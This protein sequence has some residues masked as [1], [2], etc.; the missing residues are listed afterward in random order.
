[1]R[2]LDIGRVCKR[3][4]VHGGQ[5]RTPSSPPT[6]FHNYRSPTNASTMKAQPLPMPDL[7]RSSSA[8]GVA[9]AGLSDE[10]TPHHRVRPS[11]VQCRRSEECTHQVK[12][13][14]SYL[15]NTRAD[16]II[17]PWGVCGIM[18]QAGELKLMHGST[19]HIVN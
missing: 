2:R 4:I 19:G 10:S 15:P 12:F 13:G 6:S 5:I 7:S 8:L 9:P 18:R 1:M 11:A 16:V 14:R 17:F 3:A